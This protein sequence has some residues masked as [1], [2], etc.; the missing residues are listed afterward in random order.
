[1]KKTYLFLV[2]ALCLFISKQTL[3]G[4]TNP[5]KPAPVEYLEISNVSINASDFDP[6][7]VGQSLSY[8][9][10][11]SGILTT[12]LLTKAI[13]DENNDNSE[14]SVKRPPM[15]DVGFWVNIIIKYTDGSISTIRDQ[16]YLA[17]GAFSKKLAGS[18]TLPDKPGYAGFHV[19]VKKYM[20]STVLPFPYDQTSNY[21]KIAVENETITISNISIT[22][23]SMREDY[24]VPGNILNYSFTVEGNYGL[25]VWVKVEFYAGNTIPL[26]LDLEQK[27]STCNQTISG[28]FVV[29]HGLPNLYSLKIIAKKYDPK[30]QL[31][32]S[33][34]R[35]EFYFVSLWSRAK[36]DEEELWFVAIRNGNQTASLRNMTNPLLGGVDIVYRNESIKSWILISNYGFKPNNPYYV[37]VKTFWADKSVI[38]NSE[39]IDFS[40]YTIINNYLDYL[41]PIASY[42]HLRS[43]S[44][45]YVVP[46]EALDIPESGSYDC[47]I[48][49]ISEATG[50]VLDYTLRPFYYDKENPRPSSKTNKEIEN[51]SKN[52][53]E[54]IDIYPN[55]SAGIIHLNSVEN[56]NNCNIEVYAITGAKV[57]TGTIEN[58]ENTINLEKLESGIYILSLEKDGEVFYKKIQINK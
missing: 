56:L 36:L 43:P 8:S 23:A 31:I 53:F 28:S 7:F 10:T 11:V 16:K 4:Q 15:P 40:S 55:P 5:G 30:Y 44:A 24:F 27:F 54:T 52:Y 41:N 39:L 47:I 33:P 20:L 35:E 46:T 19:E 42:N 17:S 9:F 6:I 12:E 38:Q 13:G 34:S 26:L 18:F 48:L 3:Y 57:Y 22:N 14:L 58:S 1:M 37:N 51:I 49:T 25:G 45:C 21:F 50:E 29:P 2:I 32:T